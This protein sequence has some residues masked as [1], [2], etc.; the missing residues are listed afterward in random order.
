MHSCHRIGQKGAE[1]ILKMTVELHTDKVTKEEKLL[2]DTTVQEANVKFPTDTR[3]HMGCIEKLWRMGETE[4]TS[5]RRS[6]GRP[7]SRHF[8]PFVA[9]K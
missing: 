1:K 3:L 8:A 2:A 7:P 4:G 6:Y 5:W 9:E